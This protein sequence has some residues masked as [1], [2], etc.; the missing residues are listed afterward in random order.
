MKR[1]VLNVLTVLSLL[2]CVAAAAIWVW[3]F[4]VVESFVWHR[5][6]VLAVSP[7]QWVWWRE[8][9]GVVGGVRG[10]IVVRRH[11][12]V[13]ADATFTLDRTRPVTAVSTS[14]FRYLR[15]PAA[16][17]PPTATSW[18]PVN[19]VQFAGLE[20]EGFSYPRADPDEPPPRDY[21][22]LM[23]PAW[24]PC[25]ATALLPA[26]GAV[27][28]RRGAARRALRRRGRCEAC[29]Y[30]LRATPGRCPECGRLAG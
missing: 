28:L 19:H 5:R 23:I 16:Y 24:M 2:L 3:S 8:D 4:V 20:Y 26:W 1:R 11:R 25:L 27:R 29:G 17:G 22:Q 14:E 13:T 18:S 21:Y 6:I 9:D 15:R 7:G 12:Q 10:R 30:D